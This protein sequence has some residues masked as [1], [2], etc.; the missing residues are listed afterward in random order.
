MR[1]IC[2]RKN[3]HGYTRYVRCHNQREISQGASRGLRVVTVAKDGS[4]ETSGYFYSI[5]EALKATWLTS[6]K[7]PIA[8]RSTRSTRPDDPTRIGPP[9][10]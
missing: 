2:Q 9:G 7:S 1:T 10:S 8:T 3:F 4:K 5:D 6:P